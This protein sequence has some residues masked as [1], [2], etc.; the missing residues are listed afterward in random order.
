MKIQLTVS[1]R[2][3]SLIA[4][5]LRNNI[6]VMTSEHKDLTPQEMADINALSGISKGVHKAFAQNDRL[7]TDA[8]IG[9]DVTTILNH[10]EF[11]R[12][13]GASL[14]EEMIRLGMRS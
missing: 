8:S 6:E 2:V 13:V 14:K 5:I 7:R 4:G 11:I 10:D 9:Y 1:P 3:A 12:D